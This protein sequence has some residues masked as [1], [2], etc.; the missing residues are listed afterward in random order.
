[1]KRCRADPKSLVA[2]EACNHEEQTRK[3]A[4][5]MGPS[6]AGEKTKGKAKGKAKGMSPQKKTVWPI[7]SAQESFDTLLN[8]SSNILMLIVTKQ[9]EKL[10]EELREQLKEN[11]VNWGRLK[12]SMASLCSGSNVACLA[13]KTLHIAVVGNA[14]S[15]PNLF[16]VEV[17]PEKQKWLK[18]LF[19]GSDTCIFNKME[20]MGSS[21]AYCCVHKKEC[22]VPT[23]PDGPFL[24]SCGFSCKDVS[25]AN[26][27]RKEFTN[28]LQEKKGVTAISLWSLRD[29]CELHQPP[30]LILENVENFLNDT[31]NNFD[32]LK[33]RFGAIGYA[34]KHVLLDASL[35]VPQ[36]RKRVY[37]IA[38]NMRLFDLDEDGARALLGKMVSTIQSL[39]F[40]APL[41]LESFIKEK[42]HARVKAEKK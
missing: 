26:P 2:T 24:V 27:K 1:M 10:S 19:D 42:D 7:E 36:I 23:G 6:R 39:S 18:M 31:S 17:D 14:T 12:A 3:R 4:R 37:I 9:I 21:K 28:G 34:V 13:A 20:D 5:T 30:V 35:W 32:E 8:S 16:D 11:I 33:R 25:K 15:C 22:E 29:Y 41:S 38:L 40:E